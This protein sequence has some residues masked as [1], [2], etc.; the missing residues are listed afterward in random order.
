L[1]ALTDQLSVAK[2][3]CEVLQKDKGALEEE[4]GQLQAEVGRLQTEL[5]Q[6]DGQ[7]VA[8]AGNLGV[9]APEGQGGA[10]AVV[11]QIVPRVAELERDAMR[12]GAKVAFAVA[13]SHYGDSFNWDILQGGYAEGC[14]DA[15]MEEI[16][17]AATERGKNLADLF[18]EFFLPQRG[19]AP[20]Q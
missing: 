10:A 5:G 14:D 15:L 1:A 20:P 3:T 6:I 17:A 4:K 7:L 12:A 9:A 8:V 19:P 13:R 11:P 16:E 2:G 18:A